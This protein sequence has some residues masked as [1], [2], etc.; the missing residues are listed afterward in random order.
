[1]CDKKEAEER[2]EMMYDYDNNNNNNDDDY[3]GKM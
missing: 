1:M 3:M 2:G